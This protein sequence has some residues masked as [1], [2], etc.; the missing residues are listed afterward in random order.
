MSNKI[1]T[2]EQFLIDNFEGYA[3][4]DKILIEFAKLHVKAALEAAA[5]CKLSIQSGYG[6]YQEPSSVEFTEKH[7][8]ARNISG[9]GDC[10]YEIIVPNLRAIISSYPETNIV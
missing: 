5:S 6:T 9:H 1:P 8:V 10:S 4:S 2:A 7:S 3:I